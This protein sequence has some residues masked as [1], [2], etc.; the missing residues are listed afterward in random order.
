MHNLRA[1]LLIY[2]SLSR[3]LCYIGYPL[4][5]TT[6]HF[7]LTTDPKVYCCLPVAINKRHETG[8]PGCSRHGHINNVAQN[9]SPLLERLLLHL[10]LYYRL[11]TLIYKR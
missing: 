2:L 3:P 10:Q 7:S 8:V 5:F 4:L 11:P 9:L 6:S 1:C